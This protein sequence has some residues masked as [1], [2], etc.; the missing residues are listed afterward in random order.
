MKTSRPGSSA[1]LGWSGRPKTTRLRTQEPRDRPQPI[2]YREGLLRRIGR[3]ARR[4][5]DGAGQ[6]SG[7][8]IAAGGLGT[9]GGGDGIRE[10]LA[11]TRVADQA[12]FR[13]VAEV[14]TL[15]QDAGDFRVA[16]E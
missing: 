2:K 9:D 5:V 8:G 14:T 11:I 3:A 13:S 7:A 6:R 16:R 4:R 12:T 15:Q 10:F 1:Y